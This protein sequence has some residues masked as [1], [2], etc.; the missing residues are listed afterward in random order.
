MYVLFLLVFVSKLFTFLSLKKKKKN[1]LIYVMFVYI[2]IYHS[3]V[4]IKYAYWHHSQSL[5]KHTVFSTG[6]FV[7]ANSHNATV[8]E[9]SGTWHPFKHRDWLL[10][11][12]C[13]QYQHALLT[14]SFLQR[15]LFSRKS[16]TKSWADFNS[17]YCVLSRPR[18]RMRVWLDVSSIVV[19]V[20]SSCREHSNC[21]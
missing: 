9:A 11:T 12:L 20:T 10:Q 14:S 6:K 7:Q 5:N 13:P 15:T 1:L 19:P 8:S 17:S 2:L 21:V 18:G 3:I 4:Y 16:W